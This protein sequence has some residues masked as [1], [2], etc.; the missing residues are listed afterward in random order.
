[1]NY[2]TKKKVNEAEYTIYLSLGIMTFLNEMLLFPFL[3]QNQEFIT[4]TRRNDES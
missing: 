1:M 2:V 3:L 4:I